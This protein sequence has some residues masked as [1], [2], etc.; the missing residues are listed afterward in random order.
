MLKDKE[1][2]LKIIQELSE[3]QGPLPFSLKTRA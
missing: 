3:V 2:T 1:K